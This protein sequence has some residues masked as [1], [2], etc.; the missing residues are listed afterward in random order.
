MIRSTL[1]LLSGALLLAAA[2]RARAEDAGPPK[3]GEVHVFVTGPK[4][5]KIGGADATVTVYL[6]YGGFKKTLKMEAKAPPAPAAGAKKEEDEKKKDEKEEGPETHGGQVVVSDGYAVEVA[7]DPIHEEKGAKAEEE[8]GHGDD[9]WFEANAPLV[10]YQDS[11]KD[12]PPAEKAGKC[13]KCGM[14]MAVQPASFT[15]VVVVKLKDK[16]INAKGFQ[17]PPADAPATLAAAADDIEKHLAEIDKLIAGSKLD[18]VHK[19][20]EKVSTTAKLLEGLAPAA[21]RDEVGKIGRKLVSLFETIDTAADAGKADDTKKALAE[22]R[23][24]L[25]DLRKQVK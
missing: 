6:D 3:E 1:L 5:E 22:Y 25:A 4:G 14:A 15:A 16:S 13:A 10:A 23:A 12:A 21:A 11:M 2:P 8:H 19:V 18:D 7:V 17:Y 9:P 20:A 24:A